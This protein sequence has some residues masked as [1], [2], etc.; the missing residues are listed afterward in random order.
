M[1]FKN[2]PEYKK[3]HYLCDSCMSQI[4][5]NTHVLY[6]P[7]YSMLRENKN[8]NDDTHLAQYLQKVLDI[9]MKLRLE[10]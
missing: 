8:L 10:R 3:E 7:S 1:N 4:D 9:R 6:C 5:E 2:N